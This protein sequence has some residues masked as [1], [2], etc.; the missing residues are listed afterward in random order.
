V[1][2][3]LGSD[4]EFLRLEDTDG[5][6]SL[7]RASDGALDY[8]YTTLQLSALSARARVSLVAGV[9]LP[10]SSFL[11]ELAG[12]W[13][14]WK[15]A[16]TWAAYEGGLELSCTHDGLGHIALAVELREGPVP[17]AWLVRGEVPLEAG[18]LEEVAHAARR[19]ETG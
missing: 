15:G 3:V 12:H 13:S 14:G 10:L 7:R 16:R 1:E 6:E 2:L 18:Q 11:E 19:F 4:S 8:V 5:R 17:S 9:D